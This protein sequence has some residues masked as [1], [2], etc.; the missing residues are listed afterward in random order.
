TGH[1]AAPA[2]IVYQGVNRFLEHALL[3]ADDDLRRAKLQ[4]P[5]EAV[6]A[7]DDPAV[8]VVQVGGSE[9]PAVE[10]HHWAQVGRY[11]GQRSEHH[12]RGLVARLAEG[13]NYAQPLGGLLALLAGRALDFGAELAG[14]LVQVESTD[15]RED[16]L[17]PHAR[18]EDTAEQLG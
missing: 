18:F 4:Q 16:G 2:A 12:P 13:L 11:H 14:Q 7:V 6:V 1:D 9:A 17:S 15:D 5:L 3:V 10:L 8:Q